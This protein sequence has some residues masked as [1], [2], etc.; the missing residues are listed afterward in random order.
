MHFAGSS[1]ICGI[2][3][4]GKIFGPTGLQELVR[5]L[6]SNDNAL[7]AKQISLPD[8][9]LTSEGADHASLHALAGALKLCK[10]LE[11]LDLSGN[12]IGAAGLRFLLRGIE[13]SLH[14]NLH[15]LDL[16]RNGLRSNGA[17]TLG[18]F[19]RPF[20]KHHEPSEQD[21]ADPQTPE[22]PESESNP[23]SEGRA[24]VG[25]MLAECLSTLR[26][27][28][29]NITEFETTEE[30]TIALT[31]GLHFLP[32]L[33][34][35]HLSHN[36]LTLKAVRALADY[37][38][39]SKSLEELWLN[40]NKI[41]SAGAKLLAQ[42]ARV[43]PTLKQL[44]L[45]GNVIASDGAAELSRCFESPAFSI[46]DLRNNILTPWGR[47]C[48]V[49]A[50]LPEDPGVLQAL[51]QQSKTECDKPL[52]FMT[53]PRLGHHHQ[54][55]PAPAA[56]VSGVGSAEADARAQ[57]EHEANYEPGESPDQEATMAA[58]SATH[59]GVPALA[60][61]KIIPPKQL[62]P[63]VMSAIM[64]S[65]SSTAGEEHHFLSG[66]LTPR[67]ETAPDGMFEDGGHLFFKVQD[68]TCAKTVM[69]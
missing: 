15:T 63:A 39:D 4:S 14:S 5:S 59:A 30:G 51:E 40:E 20:Y 52:K 41:D 16:S 47:L 25:P 67:G 27:D 57:Q 42:A 54:Q 1:K 24:S 53:T 26:L 2:N 55:H 23:N 58:P 65:L 29:N 69:F 10:E 64:P 37:L 48:L 9:S 35:L 68:T 38:T 50:V 7:F 62:P 8:A 3:S 22:T 43:S 60:L 36:R 17:T 31:E 44:H 6:T 49:K 18:T 32:S 11:I 61:G 56:A 45:R 34:C 13:P 19:F 21:N 28:A 12:S 33:K 46:L 66:T